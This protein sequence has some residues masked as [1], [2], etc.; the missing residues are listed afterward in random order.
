MLDFTPVRHKEVTMNQF[1]AHL[2]LEDLH[3]LTD[4]PRVEEQDLFLVG[5]RGEMNEKREAVYRIHRV[6]LDD[7]Q[8]H[9]QHVKGGIL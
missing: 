8:T 3:R 9:V 5:L 1:A 4:A 7:G 6:R 2:S